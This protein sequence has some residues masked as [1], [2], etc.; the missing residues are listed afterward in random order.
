MWVLIVH[1][2]NFHKR[3]MIFCYFTLSI[4]WEFH[5]IL[6]RKPRALFCMLSYIHFM[7]RLLFWWKSL[8]KLVGLLIFYFVV[9]L[10]IIFNSPFG[11]IKL[12]ILVRHICYFC[13]W[14]NSISDLCVCKI[15]KRKLIKWFCSASGY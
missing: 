15:K 1:V 4:T 14:E 10:R 11:H 6:C 9:N 8:T 7:F 12:S 3:D 2:M 5:V 13:V